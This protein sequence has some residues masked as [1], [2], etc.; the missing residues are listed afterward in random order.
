MFIR[1]LCVKNNVQL[2]LLKDKIFCPLTDS[3]TVFLNHMANYEC[4]QYI[5]GI[6]GNN[7][8]WQDTVRGSWFTLHMYIDDIVVFLGMLP[9]FLSLF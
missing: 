8:M 6:L 7:V 3:W 9:F 4:W 5:E 2:Y 1:S